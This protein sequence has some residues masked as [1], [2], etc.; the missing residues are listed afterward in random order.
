MGGGELSI[1]LER[2]SIRVEFPA[3]RPRRGTRLVGRRPLSPAA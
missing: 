2:A 3:F 1:G